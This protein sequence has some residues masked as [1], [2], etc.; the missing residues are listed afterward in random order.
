MRIK[1]PGIE[2]ASQATS[3]TN[4]CAI[5][6]LTVIA[7]LLFA[8]TSAQ[9][10]RSSVPNSTY[11][12]GFAEYYQADYRDAEKIFSRASNGA[13]QAGGQRFLDSVC[14]MTMLGECHFQVGNYSQAVEL[15]EQALALYLDYVAADWQS[16]VRV[17]PA[18]TEDTGA[19]QKANI[20]WG[21]PQRK[22]IIP[23]MP[24]TMSYQFGEAGGVE[25]AIVQGGVA[26]EAELRPIDVTEIMRCAAIALHRRRFIKGETCKYDPFSI[27]LQDGLTSYAGGNGTLLGAFN[28]VLFGIAQASTGKYDSAQKRLVSSLQFNGSMDHPLTAI[29]L[30]ELADLQR[31][32]GNNAEAGKLALEAS[33]TGAI[34]N[35]YDVVADSIRLGAQV[36]LIDQRSVYPPLEPIIAW[37]ARERADLVEAVATIRL[38]DC[39]AEMSET[40][41]CS[42]ALAQFKRGFTRSGVSLTP[43]VG[44]AE[45]LLAVVGYINGDYASG[46]ESLEAAIKRYAT[47]S[48]WLYQLNLAEQLVVSGAVTER[49]ADTLYGAL[50]RD[51]TAAEWKTDPLET[52]SFMLSDHLGAME[53][54]FEIIVA[55]KDFARAIQVSELWKR[56]RF[57]SS[58]PMGG[59]LLAFRWMME[60][61]NN[62][63]TN[64]MKTQRREFHTRFP[65]YQPLSKEAA[66]FEKQLAVMPLKLEE[67]SPEAKTQLNTFVSL[68][69]IS[70]A[71]ESML[72][73]VALRRQAADMT[74]PPLIDPSIISERMATGEIALVCVNTSSS[75]Y[76]FE[77]RRDSIT[78]VSAVA[79]R[80][81]SNA[82]A[83]LN[84]EL[85]IL[86]KQVDVDDLVDPKKWHNAANAI[87]DA[88]LGPDANQKWD[89]VN[90]LVIV[91][92]GPTWYLPWEVLQA[93]AKDAER[94]LLAERLELRYSPTLG[95]A[96]T[97][98]LPYHRIAKSALFAGEMHSKGVEGQTGTTAET[99]LADLPGIAIFDQHVT[100]PSN[101]LSTVTDRF[102]VWSGIERPTRGGAL[103][104]YA[105][106]PIQMDQGENGSSLADWISLPFRG[107]D[108]VI[109]PGFVSDGGGGK[110]KTGG[111]DMFLMTTGMLAA[112]VRTIAIS[113]WSTSGQSAIDLSSEFV[114][115]SKDADPVTAWNKT[116]QQAGNIVLDLEKEPKFKTE[117][118]I[119]PITAEH[120]LF[121]SGTIIVNA[122][123]ASP[124][125]DPA[126]PG[127]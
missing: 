122:P 125:K 88:I 13:L 41:L 19:I 25:R 57:F 105:V 86:E 80:R 116:I 17:P 77:Y 54:W 9:A 99:M 4:R 6:I 111:N 12:A 78:L 5:T 60:A 49:Q 26:R 89:G 117:K 62:Q 103:G 82:I 112:G 81:L 119:K 94:Q 33:Y 53:R 95:L 97:E 110:S 7:V 47:G 34:F 115:Q 118:M 79:T 83:K 126:N 11:Y 61:P 92:D 59:R 24:D 29:A 52:M 55:R 64:E 20:T 15:Y 37:G 70:R 40:E 121:W 14:Y 30:L 66:N 124:Q 69:K 50:L 113:R 65:A 101:L 68:S 102:I 91:P 3:G 120:P 8:Q 48:R 123:Q 67:D 100:I 35:Q 72:A 2:Q 39:F 16:R 104:T 85:Q 114:R 63:L 107:V 44:R 51:P 42:K 1:D 32:A 76:L 106:S 84:R 23:S 21:N 31:I 46:R 93:N 90:R 96:F 56:H 75:N 71:Q 108:Q 28:G 27:R 22:F 87:S 74:F 38:A 127:G 109:L 36:H 45:Y 10:Q 18:I 58:L 98:E 73:S 43:E